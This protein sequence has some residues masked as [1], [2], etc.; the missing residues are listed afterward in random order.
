MSINPV[1]VIFSCFNS[2]NAKAIE[3]GIMTAGLLTA[4]AKEPSIATTFTD[5]REKFVS[6]SRARKINREM[7]NGVVKNHLTVTSFAL[8]TGIIA[9]A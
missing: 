6:K 4:H 1:L 8:I 5:F 7:T 9:M 3:H 2:A